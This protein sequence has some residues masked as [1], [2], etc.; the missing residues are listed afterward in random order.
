MNV[1]IISPQ[2]PPNFFNFTVAASRAGMNTLGIGDT[3]YE[4]LRPELREALTE[5]YYVSDLHHYEALVRACG[6]FTYKYGRID[7]LESHS[8]YWLEQDAKLR[9]DFNIYGLRPRDME[10]VKRKVRMKQVFQQAGIDV[11]P[12]MIV[13]TL[14]EAKALIAETGYPVVAKPDIGV[15]AVDT[16]QINNVEDLE[17][18]F[19][20]KPAVEYIIERYVFGTLYSYDGITD[21]DGHI[22]FSTA[23]SYHPSIMDVVNDDLDVYAC[24]TRVIPEELEKVGIAAVHAFNVRERFFHIEFIHS[25]ENGTWVALEMNMRPPGGP[26]LDVFNYANDIDI[27]REWINLVAFNTFASESKRPYFCAFAGRK[28]YLPHRYEHTEILTELKDFII[29]HEPIPPVFARAMGNHAYLVRSPDM[30]ELQQAIDY[31][32]A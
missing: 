16:Y 17:Q 8:E 1:V 32:L 26:M 9:E 13:T 14:N 6:Y 29:H 28:A 21:Q 10:A 5:Y 3:P 4:L 24:S 23:H 19:S 7:R 15:G 22:A 31:I 12:W 27:Y 30:D 25:A 11:A 2:F 18:F 20:H